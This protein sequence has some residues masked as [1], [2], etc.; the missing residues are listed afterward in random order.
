[1]PWSQ[2]RFSGSLTLSCMR[3]FMAAQIMSC[4]RYSESRVNKV[5]GLLVLILGFAAVIGAGW[6]A[7]HLPI[8]Q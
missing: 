4:C 1:M 8:P 7:F 6:L 5:I 3:P 2:L